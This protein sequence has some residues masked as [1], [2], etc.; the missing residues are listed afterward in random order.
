MSRRLRPFGA[1]PL[2]AALILPFIPVTAYG[3]Q[4]NVALGFGGWGAYPHFATEN[5][6]YYCRVQIDNRPSSSP[7]NPKDDMDVARLELEWMQNIDLLPALLGSAAPIRP[8]YPNAN[9][10][11]PC[12]IGIS[13][14]APH[15]VT[16]YD[17]G[18]ALGFWGVDA[19]DPPLNP[20]DVFC[21]VRVSGNDVFLTVGPFTQAHGLTPNAASDPYRVAIVCRVDDDM[22]GDFG[23][24]GGAQDEENNA[25]YV[26]PWSAMNL[27]WF[28][29]GSVPYLPDPLDIDPPE[30]FTP[31]E[32]T[33]SHVYQFTVRYSHSTGYYRDGLPPRWN[34]GHISSVDTGSLAGWDA[35][36]DNWFY[37]GGSGVA[38][39][40]DSR[41]W[42]PFHLYPIPSYTSNDSSFVPSE[43]DLSGGVLYRAFTSR[44]DQFLVEPT[45]YNDYVAMAPGLHSYQYL[46]AADFSPPDN[47]PYV[48]TGRPGVS[49]FADIRD[50]GDDASVPGT[51]LPHP[52]PFNQGSS[53][54][55]YAH[56]PPPVAGP[57]GVADLDPMTR[58]LIPLL[59]P[60]LR[61]IR[62]LDLF[63]F[64]Y[65]IALWG[66]NNYD[67]SPHPWIVVSQVSRVRDVD[68]VLV[69]P[70]DTVLPQQHPLFTPPGSF[71]DWTAD[72]GT[73]ADLG[74]NA[75]AANLVSITPFLQLRYSVFYGTES[76]PLRQNDGTILPMFSP[77]IDP[78]LLVF[79]GAANV[80]VP[81]PLW[82]S[83]A[84]YTLRIR[85]F[86]DANRAPFFAQV[87]IRRRNSGS[88]FFWDDM[89]KFVHPTSRYG[90]GNYQDG[91]LYF[92]QF[93]P[94]NLGV[95]HG[96]GPP[97][98]TLPPIAGQAN[99]YEYQFRFTAPDYYGTTTRTTIFPRRPSV[100]NA[101]LGL[102]STAGDDV[103]WFRINT[104]PQL[105]GLQVSPT[106][107]T[108]GTNFVY[109][110]TYTDPDG[111]FPGTS[112]PLGQVGDAPYDPLLYVDIFGDRLGVLKADGTTNNAGP[113]NETL[114]YSRV[115]P[116]GG[117]GYPGNNAISA[118]DPDGYDTDIGANFDELY[119]RDPLTTNPN[120]AVKF[121]TGPL[122]GMTF[123]VLNNSSTTIQVS[124]PNG[125]WDSLGPPNISSAPGVDDGDHFTVVDFQTAK[126]VKVNL[127]DQDYSDGVQ[128]MWESGTP[129]PLT[130]GSIHDYYAKFNDDA[131]DCF[132]A[133]DPNFQRPGES[134]RYPATSNLVGPTVIGND[135]PF[136]A[137]FRFTPDPP[138]AGT[139]SPDGNTATDFNFLVDYYDPNDNPPTAVRLRVRNNDTASFTNYDMTPQNPADTTYSDGATF[140][141]TTKLAVGTY[142]FK[143][144]CNDGQLQVP[145]PVTAPAP[146][147]A[148]NGWD[149]QWTGPQTPPLPPA[150]DPRNIVTAAKPGPEVV[151]NSPP[152]LAYI[153]PDDSSAGGLR[154]GLEPDSGTPADVFTYSIKYIDND[155]VGGQL[156]DPPSYVKVIIDGAEFAM[157]AVNPADLN[158]TGSPGSPPADPATGGADFQFVTATPFTPGL[159]NYAFEASD[160]EITVRLP[161]TGTLPGPFINAPPQPPASLTASDVIP[162]QGDRVV[163]RWNAS[164]D[165]GGP[166]DD[167]VEYRVFRTTTKGSYTFDPNAMGT[168]LVARVTATNSGSYVWQDGDPVNPPGPPAGWVL[169]AAPTN[170]TL[171]YRDAATSSFGQPGGTLAGFAVEFVTGAATGQQF[172]IFN[173]SSTTITVGPNASFAGPLAAGAANGDRF[174]LVGNPL[175]ASPP[176]KFT[177]YFYIVRAME[178]TLLTDLGDPTSD[179]NEA[180]VTPT[181]TVPVDNLAP[182]APGGISCTPNIASGA[183]DVTWQASANDATFG[184]VAPEPGPPPFPPNDDVIGYR[185]YRSTVT[186]FTP[187]PAN[188]IADETAGNGNL[189]AGTRTFTDTTA[190]LGTT[191][192]YMVRA[193]DGTNFSSA[194][195]PTAACT[196]SDTTGPTVTITTPLNGAVGVPQSTNIEFTVADAGTGVDTSSLQ[197]VLD[198]VPSAAPYPL[199]ALPGN[200]TITPTPMTPP[201][202]SYD[203]VWDVPIDL[204]SSTVFIVTV[205]VD[206]N[207]ATPNHTTFGGL[208]VWQFTTA[209]ATGL[210]GTISLTPAIDGAAIQVTAVGP[211]TRTV[212][213]VS[214]GGGQYTYQIA[215][216]P[217]SY[218]VAPSLPNTT[219]VYTGVPPMP[220]TVVLGSVTT[221]VNFAG[222]VTPVVAGISGR[223]LYPTG[224]ITA[225]VPGIT[226]SIS[227][228]I[229]GSE[230]AIGT[231]N[232]DGTYN[233]PNLVPGTYTVTPSHATVGF[234]PPSQV[235]ILP[236]AASEVNF[237]AYDPFSGYD[238]VIGP[239][240]QLVTHP[241]ATALGAVSAFGA[242]S[243]AN[244]A[245]WDP[246]Y[247]P[248]P[249][250]IQPGGV[251]PDVNAVL[252]VQPGRGFFVNGPTGSGVGGTAAPTD[253]PFGIALHD[254]WNL[255]GNPWLSPFFWNSVIQSRAEIADFGWIFVN[256]GTNAGYALVTDGSMLN[257]YT[258]VGAYRGFWIRVDPGTGFC[259]LTVP[260]PGTG[261]AGVAAARTV[262]PRANEPL[263]RDGWA[264]RVQATAARSQD[265]WNFFGVAS[266]AVTQAI[267]LDNPPAVADGVDVFFPAEG[268]RRLAADIRTEEP[269]KGEWRFVVVTALQN[270][271][272]CVSLAD[273]SEVPKDKQ[274][275]MTDVAAGRTVFAKTTPVYTYNSGQ[276]G[277]R[278]FVVRIT[279]KTARNLQVM[280]VVAV[281]TR[282]A[283]GAEI[284]YTLTAP[285]ATTTE[286]R[287]IAGRLIREVE[288]GVGRDVGA[289]SVVWDGRS[290]AGMRVPN[291]LYL[292][293][294]EAVTPEGERAFGLGQV[295]LAR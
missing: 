22:D 128:Y 271:D 249:R 153:A 163:L 19:G 294:V 255:A 159:H 76:G 145:N 185:L 141:V 37:P 165:D 93:S 256:D 293:K 81:D 29:G 172:P 79:D 232:I 113:G 216:P 132:A 71:P 222:T 180:P 285:A 6:E 53:Y 43:S 2:L 253:R 269:P 187:S 42:D 162:D 226:L 104:K 241:F 34:R 243:A 282:G 259:A 288:R 56:G 182:A 239:G 47:R 227:G 237:V 39:I 74:Y 5:S 97:D 33:G 245:R 69:A 170:T 46:C 262:G 13:P 70:T 221:G 161:L 38:L 30:A 121:E 210:S 279:D 89:T 158:Y 168:S 224:D 277:E 54:A 72:N 35:S 133:A 220:V 80:S 234:S 169:T 283:P 228:P 88:P 84:L 112:N 268:N 183:I 91:E 75:A 254:E 238:V 14:I 125:V 191:Y 198:S 206:D 66:G 147:D 78:T 23:E 86:Q 250:Y 110:V 87:G 96:S 202:S 171:T 90:N 138:P 236:P 154:P 204:A 4:P 130:P 3:A 67:D 192:Y 189:V 17:F 284:T 193:Y 290:N 63:L 126:M 82:S 274:V 55:L 11:F 144:Q 201:G 73:A 270:E 18:G 252:T 111:P 44:G 40:V 146:P 28:T 295:R 258:A 218:N 174:L 50:A 190:A 177:A 211:I 122:R 1:I 124:D 240:T 272:V 142:E 223:I 175:T 10:A 65:P 173:N 108:E 62:G 233:F 92:Y 181:G 48:M 207:A 195:G 281:P 21:S 230:P 229:S 157:T 203:V 136:L 24:H 242:G 231:L 209:A 58:P 215:L 148:G 217:G 152:V 273:L 178:S 105:A 143:A 101:D 15:P 156:G 246:R 140:K 119:R 176:D 32:G 167:V 248:T 118:P 8:P 275:V 149:N 99:D 257:T 179:S 188:L 109:T 200:V 83:D 286:I 36:S 244:V 12:R 196:A 25:V 151:A 106:T 120:R 61:P 129:N 276:G 123:A 100:D 59:E 186:P 235:V 114:N 135:P 7:P 197:I 292:I 31:D 45:A 291:G 212:T 265:N 51:P 9:T 49:R 219:F 280:N 184:S 194:A 213:A 247:T 68:P 267:Q 64:N 127:A 98:P 52:I 116:V 214:I 166:T 103:Y 131:W 266:G 57:W 289:S 107:G 85:Y 260:V 261:G 263:L 264:V 115:N 95:P 150:T 251:N 155:I 139:G 287:N 20:T 27:S 164:P 208:G 160:G 134:A 199:T 16:G 60:P 137:N 94:D 225:L 205:D 77:G 41:F 117:S 278:E 102:Q 26:T